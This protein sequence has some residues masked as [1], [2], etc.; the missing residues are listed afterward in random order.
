MLSLYTALLLS[1]FTPK[2]QVLSVPQTESVLEVSVLV[3][4]KVYK[5]QEGGTVIRG[6]AG[7]SG[8]FVEEDAIL[9]AAHCFSLPTT[10][11]WVRGIDG[12]SYE[13]VLAKID[14]KKDLALLRLPDIE[15][16][17]KYAKLGHST[18]VGEQVI[19]VG[20]PLRL[21]F[22]VSEGIL[23]RKGQTMEPFTGLYILHTSMINPG[24]SGGGAFNRKGELIGVNTLSVGGPFGWNGISAAVDAQTIKE[25]LQ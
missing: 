2:T 15:E 18:R 17:H 3:R 4:A 9:T 21:E 11:V 6:V 5:V 23:A 8:T 13:A 20:S 24:S 16:G 12:I 1:L 25:F 14:P 10:N 22:L 19:S 7:C